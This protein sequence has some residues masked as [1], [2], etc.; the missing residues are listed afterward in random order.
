M[1]AARL[2]SRRHRGLEVDAE[3]AAASKSKAYSRTAPLPLW[4]NLPRDGEGWGQRLPWEPGEDR[5]VAPASDSGSTHHAHRATWPIT[6]TPTALTA[7]PVWGASVAGKVTNEQATRVVSSPGATQRHWRDDGRDLPGARGG[8]R[9][10]AR[11]RPPRQYQRQLSVRVQPVA[12]WLHPGPT[13]AAC[14]RAR[15]AACAVSEDC[16]EFVQRTPRQASGAAGGTTRPGGQGRRARTRERTPRQGAGGHAAHRR[17]DGGWAGVERDPVA[18][19]GAGQPPRSTRTRRD[20]APRRPAVRAGN[21]GRRRPAVASG[22][23]AAPRSCPAGAI[24]PEYGG[25]APCGSRL[26]VLACLVG[27]S[28]PGNKPRAVTAGE[29]PEDGPARGDQHPARIG[30]GQGLQMQLLAEARRRP[31]VHPADLRLALPGVPRPRPALLQPRRP[32]VPG[33]RHRAAG[34]GAGAAVA[35]QGDDEGRHYPGRS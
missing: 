30:V 26:A 7:C 17:A 9:R 33:A 3:Q 25:R 12:Y 1:N 23:A 2:A 21:R 16:L 11:Q 35:R 24:A 27:W 28:E 34:G 29:P 14:R 22:S 4:A 10:A 13:A 8:R 6:S 31:S 20:A 5:S 19:P 15:P 32:A 18:D